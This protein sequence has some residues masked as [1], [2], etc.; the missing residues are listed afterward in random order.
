M[1]PQYGLEWPGTG[2]VR[3]MLYWNSPPPIY[4]MTYIFKVYPREKTVPPNPNGY[5]TTFFWGNNGDFIWDSGN[6]NT[7]YGG[8]P[9]PRPAPDGEG[10]WEVSVYSKDYTTGV[11]VDW[12]R[13][14]TQAFRA[15]KVGSQTHHELYYDL[16]NTALITQSVDIEQ[17][18]GWASSNPPSPAVVI[19]QAPNLNGQSWGGYGGWEEFNGIIRGIQIYTSLLTLSEIA[20]E[21]TTPK[22]TVN[23]AASIWYLNLNPR[24]SDVTDKKASGTAHDPAWEGTTAIEWVGGSVADPVVLVRR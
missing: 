6:G 21:I 7:Y 2:S 9:Y 23:G 16:P 3:R 10:E 19:G 15:W 14:H 24:P 17:P 4:D 20:Q 8:H 22:S 12:D 5:Y 18:A 1:S 11:K 13:W